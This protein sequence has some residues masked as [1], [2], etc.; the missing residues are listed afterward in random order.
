MCVCVWMA[1]RL[2][3]LLCRTNSKCFWVLLWWFFCESSEFGMLPVLCV[4]IISHSSLTHTCTYRI[5]VR[6]FCWPQWMIELSIRLYVR[7]CAAARWKTDSQIHAGILWII[8]YV[9]RTLQHTAF[10]GGPTKDSARA[11]SHSRS[12]CGAPAHTSYFALLVARHSG[13]LD[14]RDVHAPRIRLPVA[15]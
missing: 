5:C 13:A 15:I 10:G 12:T 11:R 8:A 9:R 6:I 1:M 14:A 4:C 2:H 3:C 7:V